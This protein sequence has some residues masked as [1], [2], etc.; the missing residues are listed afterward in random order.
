MRRFGGPANTLCLQGRQ[1]VSGVSR[2]SE[3]E[4]NDL[5][6]RNPGAAEGGGTHADLLLCA[7]PHF[8]ISQ[9]SCFIFIFQF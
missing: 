3:A 1:T 7:V 5:G 4:R 6:E 2:G 8:L 9:L